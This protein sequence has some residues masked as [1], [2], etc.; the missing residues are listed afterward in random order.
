MELYMRLELELLDKLVQGHQPRLAL[1]LAG[2]TVLLVF[3]LLL[4]PR[5]AF[6]PGI[7][8]ADSVTDETAP[9]QCFIETINSGCFNSC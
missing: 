6:A 2:G 7:G 4:V 1:V 3:S 5:K 8:G 9:Y